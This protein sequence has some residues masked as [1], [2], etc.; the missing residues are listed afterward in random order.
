LTVP[1]HVRL[2][3]LGLVFMVAGAGPA[4]GQTQPAQ[5]TYPSLRIG[6][7]TDFLYYATDAETANPSSGF[8]EGQ[9]VLHYTSA[10]SEHASFFGEV[11]MTPGDAG[12]KIEVERA[13]MKFDVNDYAKFSFGRYHTPINWW[14]TAFHHG[15]WLQTTVR[16]PE[17]IQFGSKF[18]PVHFVGALAQGVVSGGGLN[19]AYDVGLGNGRAETIS[20]AGD[21]GDINNH[22]AWLVNAYVRPDRFYPLILGG[23]VYRDKVSESGDPAVR[24]WIA[25]AYAVWT[26]ETPE[27]IGEIAFVNHKADGMSESFSSR[28]YYVQGAYRLPWW[29]NR[30][31]PYARFEEMIVADSD[32]VFAGVVPYL[33]R[34]TAG[35]RTD[36]LGFAAFK[37]EVRRERGEGV[38]YVNSV[39]EQVSVAF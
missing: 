14:N 10:L 22:R 39:Y 24:E 6:G 15:L 34:Y 33:R 8:D 13:I 7:F 16:R 27:L 28:A 31:K 32:P 20:R 11:S 1:G 2:A 30:L 37:T 38:D 4:A 29:G 23:A 35:I 18:L 21:A 36:V 26:R 19:L 25:S 17:M 5:P 3:I 12:F 9:L